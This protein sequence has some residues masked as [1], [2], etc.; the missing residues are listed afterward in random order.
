MQAVI[1]RRY[2][3]RDTTSM[4]A[5]I[6]FSSYSL[7]NQ[8]T[9]VESLVRDKNSQQKQQYSSVEHDIANNAGALASRWDRGFASAIDAIIGMAS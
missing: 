9:A 8:Q 3:L 5:K 2:T 1:V 7:N 6:D 4:D